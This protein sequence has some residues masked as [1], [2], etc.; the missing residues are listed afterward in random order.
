MYLACGYAE[1]PRYDDNPYAGYWFEKRLA[2]T[3]PDA[4]G[5][6]PAEG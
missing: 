5:P 3:V 1:I 4:A 6:R 2:G